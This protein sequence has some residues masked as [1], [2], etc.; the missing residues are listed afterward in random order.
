MKR[1][2]VLAITAALITTACRKDIHLNLQNAAGMMVIEGHINDL[3]GPY[4]V[5]LSKTITFYDS[6]TVV[7]VS[8]GHVVITDDAGNRDSLKEVAPGK[9]QTSSISGVVGRTYHLSV[10]AE[11]KQ[12]DASSTMPAPVTV[13]SIYITSFA[14]GANRTI[15]PT[16]GYQDPISVTNYYRAVLK[17]NQHISTKFD[18]AD[19]KLTNG[20]TKY[21]S[22][23]S[24]LDINLHDTLSIELRCI[25]EPVW[26]YYNS[27]KN[28]ALSTQTAAPA[29]PVSN[30]SNNALGYFSAYSVTFSHHIVLDPN[31]AFHRID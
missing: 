20:K 25:D 31:G 14:F 13:D 15:L 8:G 23:R 17:Q 3:A 18:I 30:I 6:N 28:S 10:Y 7:P 9:Y 24:D 12:Y 26:N 27:L 29:N 19:D 21:T 5:S 1:L 22:T 11:G 16:V 4:T 2:F